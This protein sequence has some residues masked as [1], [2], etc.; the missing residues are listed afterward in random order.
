MAIPVTGR[1]GLYGC[2]MLRISHCVDNRLTVGGEAVRLTR[3]EGLGKLIKIIHLIGSRTRDLPACSTAPQPQRYRVPT[4]TKQMSHQTHIVQ[5]HS[6]V[7][8]LT[9]ERGVP[10]HRRAISMKLSPSNT[11]KLISRSISYFHT[12][13]GSLLCSQD[14]PRCLILHQMNL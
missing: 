1:G 4:G 11:S 10:D 3:P 6:A 2:E 9:D 14:C 13:K 12:R 8:T 7:M 5:V